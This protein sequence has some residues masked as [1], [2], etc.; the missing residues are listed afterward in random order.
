MKC[1]KCTKARKSEEI[2]PAISCGKIS[3]FRGVFNRKNKDLLFDTFIFCTFEHFVDKGS[4]W[5]DAII[6]KSG[7]CG[8]CRWRRCT[9]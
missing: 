8:P 2:G 4:F 9:R 5:E 6:K 3:G 1:G 7:R